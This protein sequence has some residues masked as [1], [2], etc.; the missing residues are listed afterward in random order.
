MKDIRERRDADNT[1]NRM[2][3]INTMKACMRIHKRERRGRNGTHIYIYSLER[4]EERRKRLKMPILETNYNRRSLNW[5]EGRSISTITN[6][7]R[8]IIRN[9]MNIRARERY[10][11]EGDRGDEDIWEH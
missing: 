2:H 3:T 10:E 4:E 11:H 9:I 7:I 1:L 8:N 6:I 5:V